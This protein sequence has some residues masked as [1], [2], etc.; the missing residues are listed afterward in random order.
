MGAG[1]G[2]RGLQVLFVSSASAAQKKDH[3]AT[4]NDGCHHAF[5]DH[6]TWRSVHLFPDEPLRERPEFP[7]QAIEG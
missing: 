4:G 3:E 2:N 5:F 6:R 7:V 1:G